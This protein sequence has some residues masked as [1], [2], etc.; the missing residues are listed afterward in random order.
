MESSI[1]SAELEVTVVTSTMICG[2]I[3]MVSEFQQYCKDGVLLA[4]CGFLFRVL[5]DCRSHHHPISATDHQ[6]SVEGRWAELQA[7]FVPRFPI[8]MDNMNPAQQPSQTLQGYSPEG[9]PK[10]PA[11]SLPPDTGDIL[12]PLN[13][14]CM[15]HTARYSINIHH[16][17]RHCDHILCVV[18]RMKLP[19]IRLLD[20]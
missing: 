11:V 14:V 20:R 15:S 19:K 1:F 13:P 16:S 10:A 8:E 12:K 18:G 7:S 4:F 2:C 9:V 5:H 6:L 17:D 3:I